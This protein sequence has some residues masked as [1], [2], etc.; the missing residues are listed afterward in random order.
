MAS[1]TGARKR[2]VCARVAPTRCIQPDGILFIPIRLKLARFLTLDFLTYYTGFALMHDANSYSEIMEVSQ[3][4]ERTL[5]Y[6][7]SPAADEYYERSAGLIFENDISRCR[8]EVCYQ[9]CRATLEH[10]TVQPGD[11]EDTE[12]DSKGPRESC[13]DNSLD[14]IDSGDGNK[15][16]D[17]DG[18]FWPSGHASSTELPD[19]LDQ[20]RGG[21]NPPLYPGRPK[22]TIHAL[23]VTDIDT[24]GRETKHNFR[25]FYVRQRHSHSRLQIT[26]EVFEELLRSCHAFPRFNEYLIGFG[27]KQSENEVGPPPLK[28]R[29]LY[30]GRSTYRQG[31]GSLT[32]IN[33]SDL[34]AHFYLEC[35]YILRYVEFT[36][37]PKKKP[38]SLR[39]FAVYHRYKQS[40]QKPCSTWILVGA[41][42]RTEAR[43]DH[44]TRSIEDLMRVNPFELHVIF[45]DTAIATWR[46]YLVYLT[47]LVAE[48]VR[49][50][51]MN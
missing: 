19:A 31:F 36:D 24:F 45:L 46:P 4:F 15:V 25:V 27:S 14:G 48:Q 50:S 38:W 29:A 26:K 13:K 33:S 3:Y 35:S 34:I 6:D 49:T 18:D 47:Q 28:F 10:T 32:A 44:Y 17:S 23:D 37:R 1:Q 9:S 5:F 43:L 16:Y 30:T 8:I 12:R 40:D 42:Q 51:R 39:Q 21:S 7:R 22:L 11:N 41:S 2:L 20:R